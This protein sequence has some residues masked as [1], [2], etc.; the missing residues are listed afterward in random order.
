MQLVYSKPFLKKIGL[1]VH[2]VIVQMV[3]DPERAAQDDQDDRN[4][5]E[6]DEQ[7]PARPCFAPDIEEADGLQ[8]ELQDGQN[9]KD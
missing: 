5:G 2:H 7:V 8:G 9:K 6:K 4:G 3:H 1:L